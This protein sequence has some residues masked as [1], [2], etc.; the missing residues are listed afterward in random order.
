MRIRIVKTIAGSA[1]SF[2]DGFQY[3]VDGLVGRLL[4]QEGWAEPA[5]IAEHMSTSLQDVNTHAE[6]SPA[7]SSVDWHPYLS[8]EEAIAAD[9]VLDELIAAAIE[10]QGVKH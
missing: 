2:V 4:I 10:R 8:L 9:I 1:P 6:R 5:F 3:E 7:S